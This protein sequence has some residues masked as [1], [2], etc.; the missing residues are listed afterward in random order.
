M[1]CRDSLHRLQWSKLNKL[2]CKEVFAQS[3]SLH[4][5][6]HYNSFESMLRAH[7]LII[8]A[9]NCSGESETSYVMEYDAPRSISTNIAYDIAADP[10]GI[11]MLPP[12]PS[13]FTTS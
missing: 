8:D 7:R 4:F 3:A 2:I 5:A 1:H 13:L 9:V 11:Q 12:I 10:Y 6:L